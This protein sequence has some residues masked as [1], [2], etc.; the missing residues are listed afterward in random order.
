MLSGIAFASDNLASLDLVLL[1]LA[2]ARSDGVRCAPRV[3]VF[4]SPSLFSTLRFSNNNKQSQIAS[5]EK[6]ADWKQ[7]LKDVVAPAGTT[8]AQF[9]FK[10]TNL[11]AKINIEDRSFAQK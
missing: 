11:N 3:D 1:R 7:V 10:A 6:I 9:Q 4:R 2:M 5:A 8:S